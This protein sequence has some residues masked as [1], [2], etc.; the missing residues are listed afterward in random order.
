MIVGLPKWGMVAQD[1]TDCPDGEIGKERC[2]EQ[3]HDEQGD[4]LG[5]FFLAFGFTIVQ[6]SAVQ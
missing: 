6:D 3:I 2:R 4:T 1:W 5:P